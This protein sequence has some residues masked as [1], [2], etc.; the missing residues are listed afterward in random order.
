MKKRVE[1][2]GD[3][4]WKNY[5]TKEKY[6]LV[7]KHVKRKWKMNVLFSCGFNLRN[8]VSPETSAYSDQRSSMQY[9]RQKL[10][11]TKCSSKDKTFDLLNAVRKTKTSIYYL[12]SLVTWYCIWARNASDVSGNQSDYVLQCIV[13]ESW[14]KVFL[15][16]DYSVYMRTRI[17]V[18]S[19]K[20]HHFG[21]RPKCRDLLRNELTLFLVNMQN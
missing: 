7:T 5:N 6:S 18:C 17:K 2:L 16:F 20:S 9:K 12:T 21:L 11:S 13:F 1:K 15:R 3:M 10:W 19:R 4:N 8:M 14:A